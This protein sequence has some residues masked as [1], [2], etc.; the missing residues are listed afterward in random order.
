MVLVRCIKNKILSGGGV[1]LFGACTVQKEQNRTWGRCFTANDQHH[2][3]NLYFSHK[4][5]YKHCT[6]TAPTPYKHQTST[7]PYCAFWAYVIFLKRFSFFCILMHHPIFEFSFLS[8]SFKK[9]ACHNLGIGMSS[10]V[11]S[12]Y[13]DKQFL[14]KNNEKRKFKKLVR[15]NSFLKKGERVDKPQTACTEW[16]WCSGCTVSV[17][18]LFGACTV[19]WGLSKVFFVRC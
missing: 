12:T 14:K 9:I 6:G 15:K 16:C 5:P 17:R 2:T 1:C 18:C 10:H 8:C 11:S 3:K 7:A 13:C 4:T 19:F